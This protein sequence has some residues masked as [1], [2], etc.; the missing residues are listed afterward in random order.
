MSDN[1]IDFVTDTR[2]RAT[3]LDTIELDLGFIQSRSVEL[4][5]KALR[6][7]ANTVSDKIVQNHFNRVLQN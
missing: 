7:V 5:S 4:S 1:N 6:F 3:L 2:G